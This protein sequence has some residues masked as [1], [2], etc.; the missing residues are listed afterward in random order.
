MGNVASVANML[1]RAGET[2][3]I[4]TGDPDLLR[5]ADKV[6]LPG[7]G[8]FDKGMR[9]LGADLREALDEVALSRRVPVLGIC[10]GMH[11]M[12]RRSEEGQ[13][14]GLGWIAADT[15]RFRFPPDSQL[16][17]P[18][19][20]WGYA[21]STRSNPLVTDVIP[22]RFYFV[23]GY[24]VK[25]DREE[26]VIAKAGYG[27]EFTCAFHHDNLFGVQFHPE[28]SHSFGMRLLKNFAAL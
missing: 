24:F 3:S 11:L 18:H 10:L 5:K 26:D 20:G 22:V 17:V 16:K 1:K 14:P 23:H 2:D 15:V 8:A 12:T 6:I 7:V 28:K 21:S 4:L 13:S 19:V 27:G 9:H 25:C